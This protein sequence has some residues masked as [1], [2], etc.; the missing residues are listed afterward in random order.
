MYVLSQQVFCSFYMYT[1]PCQIC[2]LRKMSVRYRLHSWS[3]L[4]SWPSIL[5]PEGDTFSTAFNVSLAVAVKA[6][7]CILIDPSLPGK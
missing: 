4:H 6:D 1:Q 2:Y 5:K 3:N 7:Q